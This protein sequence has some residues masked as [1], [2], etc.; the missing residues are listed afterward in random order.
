MQKIVLL[1]VLVFS[2]SSCIRQ[3]PCSLFTGFWEG[4]HPDNSD[5]KFYVQ[6]LPGDSCRV[7][8]Y[9]T[10][11]N[12]Y[13]SSFEI[14][15]L[16]VWQDNISFYVP[17]WNCTYHGKLTG[18]LISGGF[19]CPGEAFDSVRLQ[20]NDTISTFL[21]EALSGCLDP[22]YQ[23]NYEIPEDLNDGLHVAKPHTEG[24][25]E[26]INELLPKIISGDYGRLNS[27]L[28][29]K[30]NQLICEE[31]FYG[32]KRN[33]L[34][35]TESSSKSITSLLVG[36]AVDKGFIEDL[37]EPLADILEDSD[38]DER[39]TIEHLLTMT[40][41][42]TPNDYELISSKNRIETILSRKLNNVPGHLFQY[43]GGNTELL[44]AVI[45][46]KI[47]MYA[48]V[49]AQK[50]LFE[51]LHISQYCWNF[52]KQS[53]F[54]CMAGSLRITPRGM[55]KIGLLVLNKGT[56]NGE[57]VVSEEWIVKSTSFKTHTNIPG[58]DYAYQWWNITLE[59]E[60]EEYSC[61]WANGLGSQ[62]I[63]MIP[64]LNVVIVTTGHNYEYDSWAISSGIAKYLH[65]LK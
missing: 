38:F 48:D 60:G 55:A 26:F 20:K 64:S 45:K 12:F 49:F 25:S 30:N 18:K 22:D 37:N 61:I 1:F 42:L 4:P 16:N 32:Y 31:Y 21:S 8:G 27:F 62:F 58:D 2:I 40:S 10:E 6:I 53:G 44:G 54:P 39:I 63:Y 3:E 34:H 24:E 65:L 17:N 46:K 14:D 28:L 51:P 47:G 50:Y 11:K 52:G 43:D 5:K 9:W 15:S 33:T 13:S 35:H 19:D 7:R 23:Y 57:R 59:S 56:F 36:I 29:L 41:G